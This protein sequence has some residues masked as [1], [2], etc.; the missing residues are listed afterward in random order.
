[1]A[2]E[3][4]PRISKKNRK[5]A[6]IPEGI[7][8]DIFKTSDDKLLHGA[9]LDEIELQ[10]IFTRKQ[11]RTKFN[12]KSLNELAEN[13]KENGL[14]QPLVIHREGD[15]FVLLCGERRFRAMQLIKMKKAPCFILEGKS[16][17]E[18]MAIQFSENSAREELHYID[19]ADGI[20]NYKLATGRSERKITE[21]LGISKSEVHRG[22]LIAKLSDDIKLAAKN[23]NIEKYV[24]IEFHALDSKEKKKILPAIVEG[25]IKRRSDLKKA[26]E[27]K[28]LDVKKNSK[29]KTRGITANAFLK[30]MN[31]RVDHVEIDAQMKKKLEEIINETK[32]GLEL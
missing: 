12:D 1:M 25:K 23:Y 18:L 7:N 14:I 15:K 31:D 24:L 13:I 16:E 8:L 2:K 30:A 32:E 11:V 4:A 22:L 6:K 21:D 9:Q 29:K 10:K 3:F 5:L 19:K 27:G 20:M 17:K 26:I 28:S